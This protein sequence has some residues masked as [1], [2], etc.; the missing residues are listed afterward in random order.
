MRRGQNANT[1]RTRV[2]PA[3][4]IITRTKDRPKLL[5]R[6]LRSVLN[7]TWQDWVWVV[8]NSGQNAAVESLLARHAG[9]LKGRAVITSIA[10][11]STI[12]AASNAG[13][14]AADSRFIVL[15]DDDDTWEPE[16]LEVMLRALEQK[17]HSATAGAA[18]HTICVEEDSD[19]DGSMMV[20][21]EYI[22]NP[23]LRNIS[24]GLMA[25]VNQF[26]VHSFMYERSVLKKLRG[27]DETLP[28]LDDWEFNLRFLRYFDI[29]FVPRPL[30][31]YHLRPDVTQA[32][33]ANSQ[34]VSEALHHHYEAHIIN[35]ALRADAAGTGHGLGQIL[36]HAASQRK[37]IKD[38]ERLGRRLESI[39]K[40]IGCIDS[41]TKQMK[42]HFLR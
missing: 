31:R 3:V 6:T 33:E 7:Q 35:E 22:Q 9:Q 34:F 30:A 4:S 16:F 32:E 14:A 5:E 28:V 10:P 15:L 40:K 20:K 12:S 41:R 25:V 18:C 11:G 42:D 21:K 27:Y 38:V 2:T 8:V 1:E 36:A 17:P 29:L 23:R 24:L 13:I 37:L 19:A 39:S 26:C